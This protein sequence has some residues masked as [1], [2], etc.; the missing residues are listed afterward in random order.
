MT[1]VEAVLE[2]IRTLL[3]RN[4]LNLLILLLDD[5]HALADILSQ[6][7]ARMR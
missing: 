3:R 7:P 4:V 1:E 5:P 2:Q 6:R